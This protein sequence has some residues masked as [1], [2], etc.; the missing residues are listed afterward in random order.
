MQVVDF[1]RSFLTLRIDTEKKPPQ[2]L[3]HKPPYS[4]NNARIQIE[5][6]CQVLDT[7]AGTSETFVLGANCKTEQVGVPRDVWL[8]PNADFVPIVSSRA[9]LF[10]KTYAQVGMDVARYP[11]GTGRQ[12][13]R[14]YGL[15]ADALDSLRIDVVE[16]PGEPLETPEAIVQAILG[17]RTLVARTE[18][19]SGRY[20]AVIDYPVRTI[21]GNERDW[22]YQTD[23]GPLLLPDFDSRPDEV[24][25][26]MELA[27]SAFNGPDWIEMIVR[28]PTPVVE[29][30]SVYHYTRTARFDARNQLFAL[31]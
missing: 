16:R 31:D 19:T 26:R 11:L 3:S 6:R 21:N 1:Q 28:V 15:V 20:R 18:I 17:N 27:F 5:C 12:S 23:T 22:I 13:D 24:L 9:F 8:E 10:L 14:Q 25:Q 7:Q 30:V 29:G 4:L 2:S